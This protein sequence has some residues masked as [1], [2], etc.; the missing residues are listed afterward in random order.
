MYIELEGELNKRVDLQ[1]ASA[2]GTD[3]FEYWPLRADNIIDSI[4]V[5]SN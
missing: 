2:E 1:V 3:F 4:V 5:V